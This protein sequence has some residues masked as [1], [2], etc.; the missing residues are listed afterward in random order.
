[1]KRMD[2]QIALLSNTT[3]RITHVAQLYKLTIDK[4]KSVVE[5]ISPTKPKLFE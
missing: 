2:A 1:M 5:M 4:I 3:S